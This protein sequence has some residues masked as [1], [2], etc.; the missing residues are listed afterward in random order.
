MIALTIRVD[1]LAELRSNFLKAPATTLKYLSQA[2]KAAIFE[3][4]KQAIDRN[5]QF[6]TPRAL[7]TGYLALSFSFGRQID[8]SGLRGSIGPTALYAPYVYFGTSRGIRPNPYMDRIAKAAE[9]GVNKQFETALDKIV[10]EI[11][12]V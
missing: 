9:A 12:D 4:E 1:N 3:V 11:A 8:P 2:T 7:R 6:K 10:T 5:F